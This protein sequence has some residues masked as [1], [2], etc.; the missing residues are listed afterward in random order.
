MYSLTPWALRRQWPHAVHF[1]AH[2]QI[3]MPK[4][5][6]VRTVKFA[7]PRY[8]VLRIVF[9]NSAAKQ[10]QQQILRRLVYVRCR[11]PV[12]FPPQTLHFFAT[13]IPRQCAR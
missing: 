1:L 8:R 3:K 12:V 5:P 2:C 4:D 7:V 9:V 10:P 6:R 11:N 13:A